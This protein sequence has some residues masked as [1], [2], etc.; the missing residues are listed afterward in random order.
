MAGQF[1]AG[2]DPLA[3]D[4]AAFKAQQLEHRQNRESIVFAASY[5]PCGEYLVCGTSL[6]KLNVWHLP[7]YMA[8]VQ[9]SLLRFSPKFHNHFCFVA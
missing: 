8:S 2:G 5:S 3:F 9:L 4:E 1:T 7:K 6:G